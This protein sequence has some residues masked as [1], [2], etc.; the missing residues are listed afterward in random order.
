MDDFWKDQL[1]VLEKDPDNEKKTDAELRELL[2]GAS[3]RVKEAIIKEFR[4]GVI[5]C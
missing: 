2:P 1:K 4:K 5:K 3:E